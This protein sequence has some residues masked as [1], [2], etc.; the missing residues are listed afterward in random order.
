MRGTYAFGS[1]AR[2]SRYVPS[3]KD[4]D[5]GVT[6]AASR[7]LSLAWCSSL[8]RYSC[9][10]SAFDVLIIIA[11]ISFDVRGVSAYDYYSTST[12]VISQ[13]DF[14]HYSTR[15]VD[16]ALALVNTDQRP[17]GEDD[18]IN[19]LSSLKTFL[20]AYA[21]LWEGVV[22]PPKRHELAAIHDLRDQLRAAITSTEEDEAAE[23][24]NTMLSTNGASPS[25]SMHSG[26]PHLHFEAQDSTMTS[27]LGATTAMGL[28][29]V[30]VEHGMN[31]F[32][33]CQS[34]TCQDVFVDTS[35]NRSRRHCSTQCSTREAVIAHRKRNDN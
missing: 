6:S 16:L 3:R 22:Q 20:N 31:R 24:L 19:N 4:R 8:I 30:L 32:G 21:D 23:R 7:A 18:E 17:V 1:L 14:T 5:F 26:K 29:T 25:V 11:N 12:S 15:P 13:M 33:S 27:W 10:L 9:S 35:R 2:V 34:T 28:A